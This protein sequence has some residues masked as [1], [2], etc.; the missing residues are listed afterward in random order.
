[1][2]KTSSKNQIDYTRLILGTVTKSLTYI[3]KET[4]KK[5]KASRTIQI[6]PE[7]GRKGE[8]NEHKFKDK[9]IRSFNHA[10]KIVS[11]G[12]ISFLRITD[13]CTCK[14]NA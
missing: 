5:C 11:V 7:C 10:G 3:D 13:H 1:M 6:C 9:V 8:L 14:V 4:G 12:G 2:A